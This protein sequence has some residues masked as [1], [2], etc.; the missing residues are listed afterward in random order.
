MNNEKVL[1]SILRIVSDRP[2]LSTMQKTD[3]VVRLL[4]VVTGVLTV[5]LHGASVFAVGA[6]HA[7]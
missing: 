2:N 5:A 1:S 7:H 3:R 6:A 4:I